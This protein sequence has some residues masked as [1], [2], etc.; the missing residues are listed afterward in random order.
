MQSNG[1]GYNDDGHGFA[2]NG[3]DPMLRPPTR[4]HIIIIDVLH[5]LEHTIQIPDN[6]FDQWIQWINCQA[7]VNIGI[8]SIPIKYSGTYSV[9][10]KS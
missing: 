3:K 6:N 5:H 10:E 1:T 4:V 7:V 9:G 2:V 8:E